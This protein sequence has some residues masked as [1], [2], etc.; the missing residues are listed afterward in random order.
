[1]RHDYDSWKFQRHW[2][3]PLLMLTSP[4]ATFAVD[5]RISACEQ[6]RFRHCAIPARQFVRVRIADSSNA[7]RVAA[8][9]PQRCP[10]TGSGMHR[11]LVFPVIDPGGR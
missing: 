8:V 6:P 10:A 3:I 11:I 1:M 2:F 9:R 7:I 4:G 5:I